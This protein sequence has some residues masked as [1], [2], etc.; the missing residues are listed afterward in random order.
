MRRA[1]PG[2]GRWPWLRLF[3][4]CW[5]VFA[6]HF[7][8]NIVREHYP[9]FALTER[10][11]FR[12]DDYA[13][14]H[15]D[16]FRHTDGHHYIGNQV[17][18]SAVAAV[19]LL[20]FKPVLGALEERGKRRAAEAAAAGGPAADG[21]YDTKYPMRR[22]FFRKVRDRGIDL[23]LGAA[24]VIT[25]V[26]LMAPLSALLVAM[27][28]GVLVRRRVPAPRAE[29]LALIFAFA[30]PVLYRSSILNH[31]VFLAMTVLGSFLL[32]WRQD[33]TSGALPAGRRFLAGMLAGACVAL[34]YAGIVPLLVL[35]AYLLA[36][37][38]GD[39]G[40]RGALRSLPAFVLGGVPPALFLFW[41]QW[42]MFGDPFKPG[43]MWMPDQ[44]AFVNEGMRGM[45]WPDPGLALRNLIDLDWGMYTFGPLLILG[46]L[47][48]RERPGSPLILPRLERRFVALL[49]V[50]FMAFCAMNQY[51]RLQWNTG[52]RYLMPL[53]PLVFLQASD[54]LARLSPR[55]LAIV[56]VPAA[57]HTWVLTMVRYTPPVRG[58][59]PAV[60]ESWR[61]F[62]T[63]GVQFPWLNVL[64][65]T[66]SI[67]VPYLDAWFAPYVVVLVVAGAVALVWRIGRPYAA[68]VARK[69]V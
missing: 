29:A 10:G 6:A 41:S 7:A 44:N 13:D 17:L 46:L 23:K 67:R 24:A 37:H 1:A 18:G 65:S 47:P 45:T 26:F 19:P 56:A 60:V 8:T 52:F 34:D 22:A 31:N 50:G 53:V 36:T 2:R 3:L 27:M 30:T 4:A 20:V 59:A 43:Q 12:C 33:G 69:V 63:E 38:F 14:L 51:S 62:L 55:M 48:A 35:T 39:G 25:S 11:D 5:I 15:W 28:A 61:R 66:P 42:S 57:L 9:A 54:H 58:D 68:P 16:I 40:W 21:E 49:V 64:R 32:L